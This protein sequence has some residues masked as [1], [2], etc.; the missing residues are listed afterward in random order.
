MSLSMSEIYDGE[1]PNPSGLSLFSVIYNEWDKSPST[2]GI[3][4]LAVN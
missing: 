3:G 2:T 1:L 4:P